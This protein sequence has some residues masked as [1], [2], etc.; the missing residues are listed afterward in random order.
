MDDC[1]ACMVAV[2]T[3]FAA[4]C[5]LGASWPGGATL[6]VSAGRLVPAAIPHWSALAW[7]CA[8]RQH[9]RPPALPP[10]YRCH[11]GPA[12]HACAAAEHSRAQGVCACLHTGCPMLHARLPRAVPPTHLLS[13][14][15]SGASSVEVQMLLLSPSSSAVEPHDATLSVGAAGG[16]AA[17]AAAAAAPTRLGVSGAGMLLPSLPAAAGERR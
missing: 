14:A 17:V 15:G 10:A 12:W 4:V 16:G 13:S 2:H 7:R 3:A 1:G 11:D 8:S 6:L 5:L 9:V